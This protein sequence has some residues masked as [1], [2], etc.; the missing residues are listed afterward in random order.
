MLQKILNEEKANVNSSRKLYYQRHIYAGKS[1]C[2]QVLLLLIILCLVKCFSLLRKKY[3]QQS[4]LWLVHVVCKDCAPWSVFYMAVLL[5]GS[6]KELHT[7]TKQ[8]IA[9]NISTWWERKYK[10]NTRCLVQTFCTHVGL[11]SV[12]SVGLLQLV[13]HLSKGFLAFVW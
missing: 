1:L 4:Y 12:F 6:P 9:E 3:I 7:D 10:Q 11:K 13:Y 8:G 2:I 5:V